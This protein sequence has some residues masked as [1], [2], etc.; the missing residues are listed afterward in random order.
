MGDLVL[1]DVRPWPL[2]PGG[3]A[4]DV[5][6]RGGVIAAI[7]PDLVD[8]GAPPDAPTVVD[9]AGG[10]LLPGLAD[11]RAHL[12]S[13]R[14]GLPFRPHTAAP[15]LAGLVE[16]DRV[17]WRAAEEP[18]AARATRTLGATIASGATLVRSHVQVDTDSGLERLHGVLAA[19]DTHARRC[20]VEIVAFPQ[21]GILRD[22]GT[23]ALLRR[24]D[25]R[26]RRPG[27]WHRP[28]RLRSRPRAAPRRRVRPRRAA[29]G[30]RRPAP[31]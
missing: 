27:R 5:L 3:E 12:D 11:V 10:V 26:G 7:G 23:D 8:A 6:V 16:N 31:P 20:R 17:N 13:T 24:G 21:A 15:T 30:R 22:S 19:R 4:V 25:P 2:Q 1:R 14:L 28:V 29:S 9:G 18:V